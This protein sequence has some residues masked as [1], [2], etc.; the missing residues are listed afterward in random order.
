MDWQTS[1]TTMAMI[2]QVIVD[3]ANGVTQA[4]AS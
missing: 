2:Q 3:G 4:R 1:G